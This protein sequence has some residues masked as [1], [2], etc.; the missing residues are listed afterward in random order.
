[1]AELPDLSQF[2]AIILAGG[3]SRRMGADKASLPFGDSSL[4]GAAVDA[5]RPV[6]RKVMGVTRDRRSL[7]GLVVEILEDDM[8]L[9]G[10]LVGLVRGLSNSQAPWCFVAA[11]DM[12]FLQVEV[13]NSMSGHLLDCDAVIPEYDGRLQTLH[14]FYSRSCL[15]IAEELLAQGNTS[16]RALVSHCRV[17][18]LSESDFEHLPG[19]L[20]SFHDLDTQE[21]YKDAL[22]DHDGSTES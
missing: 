12:P 15:P 6:F 8:P 20:K 5:L 9:Q 14:A 18:K 11:C 19:G 3:N 16:M 17:T 2:D 7:S 22:R 1:M 10:P 13:I 21:E 4:V